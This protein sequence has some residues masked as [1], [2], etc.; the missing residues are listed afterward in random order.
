M[1]NQTDLKKFVQ[2]TITRESISG[3]FE[4]AQKDKDATTRSPGSPE[5]LQKNPPAEDAGRIQ[6]NAKPGSEKGGTGQENK[7]TKIDDRDIAAAIAHAFKWNWG[8][9]GEKVK[10]KVENG[11]VTLEG[12]LTW[13][14]QK[15]AA[16]NIAGALDGVNGVSN[17]I[18]VEPENN[19]PTEKKR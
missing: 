10:V 3:T 8:F 1:D 7:V 13:N 18:T 14:Y 5:S 19:E 6:S 17:N 15:E 16:K 9:S 2:D 11:L 4:N 12:E